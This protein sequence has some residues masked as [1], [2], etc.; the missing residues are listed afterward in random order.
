MF[1]ASTD[2]S[3]CHTTME[4]SILHTIIITNSKINN[5]WIKIDNNDDQLDSDDE[6]TFKILPILLL[7]HK[8][9]D[10]KFHLDTSA[11]SEADDL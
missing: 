11:L 10:I 8:F 3:V 2:D 6:D 4:H 1:V 5:N 7:Q 9:R